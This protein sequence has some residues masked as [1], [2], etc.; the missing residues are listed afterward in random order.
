LF[1]LAFSKNTIPAVL[2]LALTACKDTA[3]PPYGAGEKP[4]S[5]PRFKVHWEVE[6]DADTP[7]QAA[8]TARAIQRD[9]RA[10]A[11]FE[12][13][14]VILPTLL[15]NTPVKVQVNIFED[16]EGVRLISTMIAKSSHN[17][18]RPAIPDEPETTADS[19]SASG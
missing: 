1:D 10:T 13:W 8:A 4:N 6:I 3:V 17:G 7:A 15:S 2:R 5:M 16:G 19:A 14:P 9:W 11:N 18:D 12:V